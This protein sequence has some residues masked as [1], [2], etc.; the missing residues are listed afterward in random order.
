M[1]TRI[2]SRLSSPEHVD[3]LLGPPSP[4]F[5]VYWGS[6]LKFKRPGHEINHSPPPSAEV[7]NGVQG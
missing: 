7:K 1:S 5:S 4:L 2:D 3:S 6:F